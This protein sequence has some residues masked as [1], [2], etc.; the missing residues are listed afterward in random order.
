M[1]HPPLRPSRAA[2]AVGDAVAVESVPGWSTAYSRHDFRLPEE[3]GLHGSRLEAVP[4][5]VWTF[6][7]HVYLIEGVKREVWERIV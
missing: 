4:S 1:L 2:C 3:E 7:H 6:E 5:S